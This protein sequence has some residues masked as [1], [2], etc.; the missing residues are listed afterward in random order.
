LERDN[1]G[2]FLLQPLEI[3]Q[4]GQKNLWKSLDRNSLDLE[5]LGKSLERAERVRAVAPG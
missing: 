3:P 1:F 5:I 2:F 4:N